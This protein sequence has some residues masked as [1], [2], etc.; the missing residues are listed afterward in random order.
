VR[1]IFRDYGSGMG[2]REIA[3]RLNADGVA[4]PRANV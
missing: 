4:S 3:A 1:R 2:L